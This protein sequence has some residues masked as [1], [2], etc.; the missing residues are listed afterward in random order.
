MLPG[1]VKIFTTSKVPRLNYVVDLILNEIL[2]LSWEIITDRRKLGKSCVINY[3]GKIIPGS[4]KV[5]PSGLL[6]EKGIRI[7]E[8]NMTEWK[9]LPVFFQTTD[10][11][12]LP[13]DIFAATFYLVTRYEEYLEFQPDRHGRFCAGQS[14]AFKNGFLGLPV[15]NLWAKELAKLLVRKYQNLS[16]KA[17]EFKALT[18]IDIDEPFACRG[19]NLIGNISGFLHDLASAKG[20]SGQ[21]LGC[22]RRKEKDPYEVFDY[23]IDNIGKNNAD[24][25]FFF[26]VGEHSDY[27][28]NPSWK[29]E[30]YRKLIREIGCNFKIGLYPSLKASTDFKT[31]ST[32]LKRLKAILNNPVTGSRFHFLKIAMPGSYRSIS[33]AGIIEDYSMGYPDEYGFRAGVACPVMFYDVME[34]K[35]TNL[36]IFP[37]QVMDVTLAAFKR[38]RPGTERDVINNMISETRKAGGLFISIWHNT[39]LLD[40]P[41]GREWRKVFEFMLKCQQL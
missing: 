41:E 29:N 16:F 15:I 7:Q 17:N 12:D 2:G 14:L 28:K 6:F 25:R 34:D 31:V 39:T 23:L 11:S 5:S 22:L 33:A 36:R 21:R 32:E 30:S 9:S 18:T 38:L 1:H 19:R 8:I 27:E 37:F 13:F 24:S 10:D 4:L 26:P 3:T 35:L 20:N 40:T